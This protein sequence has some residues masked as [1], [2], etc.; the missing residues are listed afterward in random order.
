VPENLRLLSR[1]KSVPVGGL[2]L[3]KAIEE[4][5]LNGVDAKTFGR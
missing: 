4:F 5:I 1:F 3:K 2:I